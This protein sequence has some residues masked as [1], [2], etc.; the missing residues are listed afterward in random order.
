MSTIVETGLGKVQ[1]F[2]Q[3]GVRVF[4]GL[5]FAKP[6]VGELR[7]RAPEKPAPWAGVRDATNYGPVAHQ[8][9]L[10]LAALPGMDVGEQ[11]E[12][13]LY[14]NVYVPSGAS[15]SSP[16]PVMVWIHGGAFVIGAGSQS[17]YDGC[18]LARRGDVVIVTINYRLGA[19]GLAICA[20][21]QP[22]SVAAGAPR[23]SATWKTVQCHIETRCATSKRATKAMRASASGT[24][25]SQ[26]PRGRCER[27]AST[28][29]HARNAA[30]SG[31]AG[32]IANSV[33]AISSWDRAC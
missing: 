16:K 17:I 21:S 14:L 1:G 15:A 19:L 30:S 24:H 31:R 26:K 5:P 10:M 23:H 12:D 11:S 9:P 18:K 27:A 29:A 4:R 3:D 7:F 33:M 32:R 2:E 20:G 25:R 22:E 28:I 6:P 8:P 13:C